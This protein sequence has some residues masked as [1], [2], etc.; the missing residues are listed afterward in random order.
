MSAQGSDAEPEALARA[1]PPSQVSDHG[2]IPAIQGLRGL[3]ALAVVA[4]HIYAMPYLAGLIPPGFPQWADLALAAGGRGVELFFI[5]SGYLIPAS[6]V[7]HGAL[8]KFFLDRALRIMP[9]FV[10]LHVVLFVIGPVIGYKF[11][12][13]IDPL[14]YLRIFLT[15]LFFIQD[16]VG[17]PIAQQNAWT[18]TYE[19]VF[20]IWFAMLFTAFARGRL[21]LAVCLAAVALPLVWFFPRTIYFG[22]GML[23]AWRPIRL[24]LPGAAGLSAGLA[25]LVVMFG[26]CEYVSPY[27]GLPPAVL[28]FAMVLS[29]R[30]G[31]ARLLETAALQFVGKIS[32]S[33]YLVH[34]FILFACLAMARRL[35]A[36]GLGPWTVFA[37]FAVLGVAASLIAAAASYEMIEVRMR[38]LIR[39]NVSAVRALPRLG[40]L[41]R[42]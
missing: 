33:L 42:S 15:N 22:L 36:L 12:A 27:A 13:G 21:A 37:C 8:S 20:Y 4:S 5:I 16:F 11:F 38:Q 32:Y 29:G 40:R 34:P 2:F 10:T 18:L 23:M 1:Q 6:L 7:R 25:L 41:P 31:F 26:L 17:D 19:W 24:V 14:S 9:V 3:A 35:V 28:L 30:N 39:R